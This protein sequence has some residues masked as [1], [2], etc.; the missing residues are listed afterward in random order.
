MTFSAERFRSEVQRGGLV[1]GL[2][3]LNEPVEHRYTGIYRLEQGVLKSVELVDKDGEIKPEFLSE[4]PLEDSFCQ[5]VLRDGLFRTSDTGKEPMLIGHK[6]QGVLLSYTGVPI[7][8]EDGSL[9]GTLCHFDALRRELS[10][11]DFEHLKEA[12]RMIP[13]YLPR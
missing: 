12:A 9:Y 1:T 2:Q 5:F 8:G 4:V 6:Y 3:L 11:E 7:V 10:E 13:E